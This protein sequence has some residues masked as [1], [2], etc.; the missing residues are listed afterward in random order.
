M[1]RPG[2]VLPILLLI[3]SWSGDDG[4]MRFSLS[5]F[6][7]DNLMVPA[8]LAS[9]CSFSKIRLNL[10]LTRGFTPAFRDGVIVHIF[11]PSIAIGSVPSSS[12]YAIAYRWRLPPRVR[13]HRASSPQGNFRN[14]CCL[15]W[16]HHGPAFVQSI[17]PPSG[18]II[19]VCRHHLSGVEEK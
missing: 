11:I 3:V 7:P 10:V 1:D 9:A 19:P 18:L 17:D 13:R 2:N 6:E 5:P 14:G 12:D 16:H 8:C 4:K 15:F